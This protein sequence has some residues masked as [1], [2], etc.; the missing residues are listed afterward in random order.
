MQNFIILS[1]LLAELAQ[2]IAPPIPSPTDPMV[3][4]VNL[5]GFTPKPT[6]APLNPFELKK[7]S[8]SSSAEFLGWVRDRC[9]Y[10]ADCK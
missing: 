3:G 4:G 2:A 1:G 7:R 9:E 8:S 5:R 10:Q 6:E